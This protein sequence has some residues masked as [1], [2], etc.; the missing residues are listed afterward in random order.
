MIYFNI[1]NLRFVHN[2]MTQRELIDKTNIRPSTLTAI[3]NNKAKTIS[4]EQIDKLCE[5]FHCQPAELMTY[6]PNGE[7][8]MADNMLLKALKR[9][10]ESKYN[11]QIAQLQKQI[12][13]LQRKKN[14]LEQDDI[15]Q[16]S[17]L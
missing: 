1:K 13:E 3:E 10:E 9:H 4:I 12:D 6:I 11:Q 14:L 5:I 15:P 17:N 16:P 8:P 2:N 7:S